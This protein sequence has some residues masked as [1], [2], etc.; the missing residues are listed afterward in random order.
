MDKNWTFSDA[1]LG[2]AVFYLFFT[3]ADVLG[4][5]IGLGKTAVLTLSC[6]TGGIVLAAFLYFFV[7]RNTGMNNKLNITSANSARDSLLGI[8]TGILLGFPGFLNQHVESGG[9]FGIFSIDFL[10]RNFRPSSFAGT[11]VFLFI[12]LLFIPF[13]EEIYFR[14][15]MYPTLSK[16]ANILFSALVTGLFS[17]IFLSGTIAFVYL[18]IS[19]FVF[20][21]LYE[22][23]EA[24][25]SSLIAHITMNLILAL[26]ILL[27]GGSS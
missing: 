19:G 14:A 18:L 5:R 7:Y 16:R 21:L 9:F 12:F 20:S 11:L 6:L 26:T 2:F 27:K 4:S 1:A 13:V 8:S 25:Y 22:K 23:T 10:S 3:L 15:F 17:S 24:A